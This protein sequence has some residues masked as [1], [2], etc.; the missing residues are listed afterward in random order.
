MGGGVASAPG[1]ATD[2]GKVNHTGAAGSRLGHRDVERRNLSRCAPPFA[3]HRPGCFPQV[4]GSRL[5]VLVPVG[6]GAVQIP[7]TLLRK[8]S[9][10]QSYLTRCL[11]A[12][13]AYDGVIRQF[14]IVGVSLRTRSRRCPT[15]ARCRRPGQE[16]RAERGRRFKGGRAAPYFL[17]LISMRRND[18]SPFSRSRPTDLLM[19]RPICQDFSMTLPFSL[20]TAWPRLMSNSRSFHWPS[21][22][23]GCRYSR[24][25]ARW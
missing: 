6:E 9:S 13:S 1:A 24:L 10:R 25:P 20:T 18:R 21:G 14:G 8:G 11:L 17:F 15:V 16:T 12:T 5:T 7:S 23:A 19:S 2:A 3:Y 22:R 4:A